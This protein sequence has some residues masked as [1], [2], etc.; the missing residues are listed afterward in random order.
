MYKGY[1]EQVD[2]DNSAEFFYGEVI[3]ICDVITFQGKTIAEVKKAFRE[4]IDDYLAFC[5]DSIKHH[6]QE[7]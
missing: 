1:I 5:S 3:N 7:E 4:S 2:V 6:I